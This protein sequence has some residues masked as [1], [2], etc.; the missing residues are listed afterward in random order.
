VPPMRNFRACWLGHS[1]NYPPLP[2]VTKMRTILVK[3]TI[4]QFQQNSNSHIFWRFMEMQQRLQ[5]RVSDH[6]VIAQ[7]PMAETINCTKASI[8]K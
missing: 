4:F 5:M 8:Q 2:G 6:L 1:T 7:Y 3:R